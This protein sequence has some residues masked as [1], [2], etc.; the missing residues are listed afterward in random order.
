MVK[1]FR[2]FT[3]QYQPSQFPFCA[4]ADPKHLTKV[5]DFLNKYAGQP[6]PNPDYVQVKYDVDHLQRN[7]KDIHTSSPEVA[8]RFRTA[9]HART[10]SFKYYDYDPMYLHQIPGAGRHS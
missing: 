8:D 3:E 6:V 4:A 2:E 1:T 7:V 5:L 9:I 10:S